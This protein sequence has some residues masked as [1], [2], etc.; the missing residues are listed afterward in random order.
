MS[1]A[2]AATIIVLETVAP[3]RGAVIEV[4]G[5]VVSP[6]EP[7]STLPPPEPAAGFG[8]PLAVIGYG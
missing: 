5:G 8:K 2:V 7:P 1:A 6:L 4:V 3:V